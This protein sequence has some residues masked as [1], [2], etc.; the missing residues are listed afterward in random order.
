MKGYNSLYPAPP[1]ST[2]QTLL[3]TIVHLG[4]AA[5]R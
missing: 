3:N 5:S 4:A 2:W 1:V